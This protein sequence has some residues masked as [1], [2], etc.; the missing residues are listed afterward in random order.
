MAS[1]VDFRERET[2]T[3]TAVGETA[4]GNG[5][6]RRGEGARG[7]ETVVG[8]RRARARPRDEE[9]YLSPRRSGGSGVAFAHVLTRGGGGGGAAKGRTINT[10]NSPL[11]TFKLW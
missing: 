7:R 4:R 8:G 6:L 9:K 11:T 5:R 2:K 1:R 10:I 3:E